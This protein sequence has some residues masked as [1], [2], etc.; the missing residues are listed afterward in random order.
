MEQLQNT[1]TQY[2]SSSPLIVKNTVVFFN[3]IGWQPSILLKNAKENRCS[4]VLLQSVLYTSLMQNLQVSILTQLW[5]KKNT[6]YIFVKCCALS[7]LNKITKI[8][9]LS[10]VV[11]FSCE[12]LCKMYGNFYFRSCV[13]II[14]YLMR[15]L[16]SM[17]F[18]VHL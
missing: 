6:T 2:L 5:I 9:M 3:Y 11:I 16:L 12:Y 14:S 15:P 17:P 13:K 10:L 1:M 4:T 8:L 18:F 7:R